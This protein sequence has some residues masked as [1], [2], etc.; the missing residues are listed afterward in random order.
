MLTRI[1]ISRSA[2][3][4]LSQ[5]YNGLRN[6]LTPNLILR[7]ALTYSLNNNDKYNGENIDTTGTEFQ[8]STLLG[9]NSE[10]FFML[11]CEYYEKKIDDDEMKSIICFHI[12]QG[13]KNKDFKDKF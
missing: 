2:T 8:I 12:E 11:I 5:K 10:I 1:K 7:N 6:S 3:G 13:L 4:L 9:S